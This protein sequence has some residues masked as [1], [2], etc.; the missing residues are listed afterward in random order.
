MRRGPGMR[1]SW[2]AAVNVRLLNRLSA[3]WTYSRR[4][5]DMVARTDAARKTVGTRRPV[6]FAAYF[7]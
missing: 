3:I 5:A 1:C 4:A 6:A 7:L 2:L